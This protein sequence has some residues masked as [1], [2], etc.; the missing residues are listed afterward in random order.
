MFRKANLSNLRGSL[1]EGNKDHLLN[2][3]RSY[4]A[5]QAL[6]VESL[7]KCIGELQRQKEEQRLAFTGR[8]IRIC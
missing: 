6:R 2:Q 8:T 3:E 7:N 5:K 4:L 1:L